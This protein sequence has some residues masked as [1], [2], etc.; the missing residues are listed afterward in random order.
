MLT[1]GK[2]FSLVRQKTFIESHGTQVIVWPVLQCPCLLDDRQ[3]NPV[4]PA[5]HGTGRYY[6]PSQQYPTI[7]L[8]HQEDS[9]RTFEDPGSWIAGSIRASVLP[10]VQLCERDRLQMLDIKDVYNDEVLTMG[11]D[12]TVRFRG[13]V[14]LLLVAD[15]ERIYRPGL[16][17][18]LTPPDTVTWQPQGQQPAFG[19][20]YAVKYEAYPE[21]LVVNDSPRLRVEHRIPQAQEVVLLRL[22]KVSDDF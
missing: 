9:R 7:L 1:Y 2:H 19:Q 22:D 8:M 20:Q 11:L 6:P 12:D 21:F 10:G 5:C 3:F 4:C 14:A 15:R 17:Y 13:G 18:L 16:D